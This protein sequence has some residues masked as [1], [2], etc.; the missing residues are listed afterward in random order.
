[1]GGAGA[2]VR[3]L[4]VER[5]ERVKFVRFSILYRWGSV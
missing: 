3:G 5:G 2:G 4:G 1:M